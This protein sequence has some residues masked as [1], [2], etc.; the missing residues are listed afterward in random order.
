VKCTCGD[1][2]NVVSLVVGPLAPGGKPIR[3]CAYCWLCW[4][5]KEPVDRGG[6]NSGGERSGEGERRHS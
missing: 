3:L 5:G 2:N 1:P 4:V 6:K